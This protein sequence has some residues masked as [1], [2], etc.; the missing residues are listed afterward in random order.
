MGLNGFTMKACGELGWRERWKEMEDLGSD[1]VKETLQKGGIP[2]RGFGMQN[3]SRKRES[4]KHT[5]ARP[6]VE[7]SSSVWLRSEKIPRIVE[8][9]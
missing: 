4:R 7:L 5:S 6:R 2:K 9:G 3:G 8:E 1:D